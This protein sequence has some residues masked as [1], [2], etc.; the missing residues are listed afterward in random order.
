M[1][2]KNRNIPFVGCDR[3]LELISIFSDEEH[4]FERYIEDQ[5]KLGIIPYIENWNQFRT[6]YLPDRKNCPFDMKPNLKIPLRRKYGLKCFCGTKF[7]CPAEVE[8]IKGRPYCGECFSDHYTSDGQPDY[9][10]SAED[11][12]RMIDE[13]MI[14]RYGEC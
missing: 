6:N 13:Y 12:Q 8:R 10:P 9:C 1:S 4:G 14:N 3:C 7:Q 2:K 11:D 5:Q